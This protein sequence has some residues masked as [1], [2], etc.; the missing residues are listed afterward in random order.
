MMAP[1]APPTVLVI[2]GMLVSWLKLILPVMMAPVWSTTKR[3][4]GVVPVETWIRSP[5][6]VLLIQIDELFDES[7]WA[8]TGPRATVPPAPE[9]D[10]LTVTM[11]FS[12]VETRISELPETTLVTP[13]LVR[14]LPLMARP[15]PRVMLPV[16]PARPVTPPLVSLPSWAVR[17]APN[18]TVPVRPPTFWTETAE[19]SS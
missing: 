16:V 5:V 10:L 11:P 14:V 1:L 4:T 6:P 17:P 19:V 12:S 13:V 8:A 18:E 9:P 2:L 3:L 15:A 7:T